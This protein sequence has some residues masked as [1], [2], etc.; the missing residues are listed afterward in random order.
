[1]T[2]RKLE[3]LRQK[4][5]GIKGMRTKQNRWTA[6]RV[7]VVPGRQGRTIFLNKYFG[8]FTTHEA[9]ALTR[10]LGTLTYLTGYLGAAFPYFNCEDAFDYTT[11]SSRSLCTVAELLVI[12][13]TPCFAIQ[14]LRTPNSWSQSF[15]EPDPISFLYS[16]GSTSLCVTKEKSV[17][18]TEK[19]RLCTRVPKHQG[20]I[21]IV[22]IF[23]TRKLINQTK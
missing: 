9:L 20:T 10:V 16:I 18:C 14:H 8:A 12:L 15:H 1:M 21:S 19:V 2:L 4:T 17:I 6:G 3:T 13:L 22:V 5:D 7:R 11:K 23:R